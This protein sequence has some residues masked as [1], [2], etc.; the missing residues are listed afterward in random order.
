MKKSSS[1]ERAY[2]TWLRYSSLGLQFCL[3]LLLFLGSGVWLDARLETE[4]WLTIVG[5]LLGI[6]GAI[7]VVVKETGGIPSSRSD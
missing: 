2:G 4:P 7:Y 1:Q 3:T 6:S 5:A